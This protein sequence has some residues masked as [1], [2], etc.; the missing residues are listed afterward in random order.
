MEFPKNVKALPDGM[1]NPPD[2]LKVMV[3]QFCPGPSIRIEL[4]PE[5]SSIRTSELE[6]GSPTLQLAAFVHSWSPPPFVQR[7]VAAEAPVTKP[8]LNTK[9]ENTIGHLF[10]TF[11]PFR[12]LYTQHYDPDPGVFS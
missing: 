5:D 3:E 1:V 6:F 12:P 11:S 4:E 8:R 9:P 10:I 2:L 7:F